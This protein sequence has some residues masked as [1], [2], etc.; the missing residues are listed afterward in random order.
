MQSAMGVGGADKVPNYLAW[1]IVMTVLGFFC[2]LIAAAPGVVAIVF[3]SQVNS[4]LTAGDRAGAL[5]ASKSAKL[6]ATIASITVGVV[7]VLSI[8]WYI[9]AIAISVGSN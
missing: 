1:S 8:V 7:F 9:V 2:C 4:K 5:S 3:A 6:W